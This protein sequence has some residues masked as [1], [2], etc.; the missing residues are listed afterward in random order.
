M[1]LWISNTDTSQNTPTKKQT[2]TKVD[3]TQ[4]RIDRITELMT[5]EI[6]EFEKVER[7][8]DNALWI[9]FSSMPDLWIEDTIDSTTRW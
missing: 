4:Q 1:I 2:E 5:A 3:V 9:Y 8:E 7:F 6:P